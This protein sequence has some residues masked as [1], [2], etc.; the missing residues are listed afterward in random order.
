MS[1]GQPVWHLKIHLG[2]AIFSKR[3]SICFTQRPN[4]ISRLASSSLFGKVAQR[5]WAVCCLQRFNMATHR[6]AYGGHW[7][8][9]WASL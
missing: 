5:E 6:I 7:P 4:N 8:L 3:R 9:R 2:R 1:I